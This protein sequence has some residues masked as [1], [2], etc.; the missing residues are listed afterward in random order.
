MSKEWIPFLESLLNIYFLAKIHHFFKVF[1]INTNTLLLLP[2]EEGEESQF[3]FSKEG[4][5]LLFQD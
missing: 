2:K 4:E 5:N 1:I 3:D